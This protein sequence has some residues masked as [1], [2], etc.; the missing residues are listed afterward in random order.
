MRNVSYTLLALLPLLIGALGG[1]ASVESS[2]VEQ[3]ALREAAKLFTSGDA[4]QL[5]AKEIAGDS[6]EPGAKT[7]AAI[8]GETTLWVQVIAVPP[9]DVQSAHVQRLI[10]Q[11]PGLT[12]VVG[13]S[14]DGEGPTTFDRPLARL[15]PDLIYSS[16]KN[17]P[18]MAVINLTAHGSC[19]ES[20]LRAGSGGAEVCP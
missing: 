13:C 6:C 10:E 3:R 11:F 4:A 7:Y 16:G 20:R 9:A 17:I 8:I 5:I 15:G 14:K 12:V 1:C 18:S 19:P 2:D